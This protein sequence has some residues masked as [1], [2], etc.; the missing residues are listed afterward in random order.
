M[1][2]HSNTESIESEVIEN[3]IRLALEQI[4]ALSSRKSPE[5]QPNPETL[6]FHNIEHTKSVIRRF[7]KIIEILKREEINVGSERV[8][9]IGKLGAAFHDTI[10]DFTESKETEPKTVNGNPNPY[11]GY[12]KIVRKRTTITNEK[13]S[14]DQAI[15]YMHKVNQS[16][17]ATFNL[18][19]ERVIR[20]Q[21][22]MTVPSFYSK[23]GTVIQPNLDRNSQ[24]SVIERA[25]AL[26][27]LGT[28]GVEN[29]EVFI[30][31][32]DAIFRE[33]NLDISDAINTLKLGTSISDKYKTYYKHRML[34]WSKFQPVFATGRKNL[35]DKEIKYFTQT[36]QDILKKEIFNRFDD[37]IEATKAV[38]LK[39]ENMTFEEIAKDMGYQID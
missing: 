32:G 9:Q 6:A 35:L 38:A 1:E 10:Q 33:E 39:R 14:A 15:A 12:Q 36:V 34:E 21:I 13:A 19:D 11:T 24:S 29:P 3:G 20:A 30:A 17:P 18:N 28:A 2:T 26:A 8:I 7:E 37:S 5:G 31:E 25:L 23:A 16:K 22:D 4:A 27:D